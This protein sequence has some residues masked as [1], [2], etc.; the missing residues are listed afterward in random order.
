METDDKAGVNEKDSFKILKA[1]YTP[2]RFERCRL[3]EVSHFAICCCFVQ[4]SAE[5]SRIA[6]C[7]EGDICLASWGKGKLIAKL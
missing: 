5:G 6:S 7:K 2:V 3:T 4:D 1:F